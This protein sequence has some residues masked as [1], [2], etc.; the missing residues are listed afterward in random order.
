MVDE[1]SLA[2]GSLFGGIKGYWI[3][4]AATITSSQPALR[5]VT[6]GLQKVG[7]LVPV[8]GELMQDATAL[9][10]FLNSAVPEVLQ[11]TVEE[12]FVNGTGAGQPLGYIN[13][14]AIKS[15]AKEGGQ[16]N[17]TIVTENI[18]KMYAAMPAKFIPDAVWLANID[19]F[20]QLVGMTKVVG[21]GGQPVW[22]PANQLAGQPH[23]TLFG[24]PLIYSEYCQTLGTTGDIQFV[25][26]KAYQAARKGGVKMDQ[27][28]HV[29]FTQDENALR[30]MLRIDGQSKWTSTLTPRHG[31]ATRSP[32]VILA[33]RP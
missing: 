13:S 26:L 16:A 14:G 5:Q 33:G 24:R 31:T 9:T 7:A 28:P 18:E 19:C 3:A 2:E 30:F 11:W 12:A 6:L 15:V 21:T 1:T 32:F 10:S 8:S 29:Y 4:E 22:L 17:T 23:Q 20:P 27:S 25:A